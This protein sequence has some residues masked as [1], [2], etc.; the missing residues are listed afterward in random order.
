MGAA[1]GDAWAGVDSRFDHDAS[2]SRAA[3][4]QR[5]GRTGEACP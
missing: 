5:A 4:R 1:S 3:T 2:G